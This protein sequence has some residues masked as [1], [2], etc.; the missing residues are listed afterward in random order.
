MSP[1]QTLSLED[2]ATATGGRHKHARTAPVR[3]EGGPVPAP[4]GVTSPDDAGQTVGRTASSY[5]G[6]FR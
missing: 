6:S 5:R 4:G 2:L 3:F 1:F